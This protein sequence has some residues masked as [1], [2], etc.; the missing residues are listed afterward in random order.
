MP[1]CPG[2]RLEMSE[3]SFAVLRAPRALL[4]RCLAGGVWITQEARRSDIVLTPGEHC[5]LAGAQKV[6]LNAFTG[7]LLAISETA[8]EAGPRPKPLD[9]RLEI[10]KGAYALSGGCAEHPCQPIAHS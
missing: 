7:A 4:I 10:T 8:P 3:Q 2:L 5:Q 1:A 9:L 6:F